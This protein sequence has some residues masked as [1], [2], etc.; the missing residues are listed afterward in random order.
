VS[1][2]P[3][4]A[5]D[6]PTSTP[7]SQEYWRDYLEKGETFM[8]RGRHVFSALPGDPRC[9]LCTVPFQG[10]GGRM[11]RLFG[12]RP[13]DANPNV[14]NT[15]QRALIKHHGGAETTGTMLFADIRG[16]TTIAEGMAPGEYRELMERF[17]RV[18]TRAVI[19]ED[20]AIDKFVGDELV[21][22]FYP[23]LA[24]DRHPARA[25]QAAQ[26]ILRETGHGTPGGP[27]LPV[28]AGVHTGRVWFGAVGEV[29]HVELTSLGDVVNTTARLASAAGAGEVL[30]SLDVAA[31][32]G[33]TADLERRSLQLKGK[34][35]PF[36]VVVVGSETD[37]A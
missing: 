35:L 19:G 31:A 7:P 28:G 10:V 23:S 17:Y 4:G 34:G 37:V 33:L 24:G 20:G 1:D 3:T 21:A 11:M 22:M 25:V 36:E 30:V 15:C 27:W 8:R 5:P 14:C 12:Y 2:S 18:A 29:P 6:Q 26:A 16:S 13:S 9:R 32:T